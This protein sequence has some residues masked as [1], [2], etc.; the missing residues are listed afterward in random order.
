MAG[1]T[2]EIFDKISILYNGI[3]LTEIDIIKDY[4][5]FLCAKLDSEN[6]HT[7]ALAL[8]TGSEFYNIIALTLSAL[9]CLFYKNTNIE[10][11]IKSLNVDDILI[12]DGQ[13]ARFKGIK[14]GSELG[15]GFNAGEEYFAYELSKAYKWVKLASA[16]NLNISVYQGESE[17][18][19]GKG[20]KSTL[21]ARKDFLRKFTQTKANSEITTEISNSIA[22]I[23]NRDTAERWYRGVGIRYDGRTVSL[24]ELV[25]AAYYSENDKYQ[26]G[27]NAT[28]EEPIIRF[29]SKISA[30][31]E[32]II[33]DKSKS[34]IGC[35]LT[36]ENIWKANSET[37][38]IADRKSLKFAVLTGK[39]HF[40]DY[41]NWFD[42]EGY[43]YYI[44]VPESVSMYPISNSMSAEIQSF[45]KELN[46]FSKRKVIE[47]IIPTTTESDVVFE[48]KRK[49]LVIKHSA[50]TSVFKDN[51]IINSFFLLNL[52]RSSIFPLCYCD[53]AAEQKL[54][55]WNLKDKFDELVPYLKES[56]GL[57][58][59]S[60]EFIVDNLK[61]L[62]NAIYLENPKGNYIKN[63]IANS[64]IDS[65][66]VTKSYY[67]LLFFMWMRDIGIAGV[68]VPK[69]V[70]VSSFA[71]SNAV[72]NN[73]IFTTA[74]YD[75]FFN[76]FAEFG[77]L[78]AECLAYSYECHQIRALKKRAYDGK[79]LIREKNSINYE[80]DIEDDVDDSKEEITIED[81]ECE[82]ELEKLA[83]DLQLSGA[84]SYLKTS[85]KGS[86]SQI[87][88]AKILTFASGNLGFFTKQ[89]KAY[90]ITGEEICEVDL[91][92][93]NVGDSVVFT[94]Q[95]DN[96]DIVDLLVRQ[97]LENQYK[98][99]AYPDYYNKSIQWKEAIKRLK[100]VA[101]FTF[102]DISDM[103]MILGCKK[104]PGTIR[105]WLFEESHIVGPRDE[106]DFEAIVKLTRMDISAHELKK[107]CDEIRSLRVRILGLL[108]K[109]IIRGMV[110]G[111]EDPLW[112]LIEAKAEDLSQIEQITAI[113]TPGEDAFVPMYLI[114]KPC[115]V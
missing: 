83:K 67:D 12:I 6:R 35:I 98:E 71:G 27:S 20:I 70:T 85:G 32:D 51:F 111:S 31:R 3:D 65:I 94:K 54:L 84:Y 41:T 24:S 66:V 104:H 52:C 50:T 29:Y 25:T 57:M 13:R 92:N 60:A 37:P 15:I 81:N 17:S 36:E 7:T 68:K 34:F 62:V 8:H 42:S 49:L 91:E 102:Q 95:S 97:L 43:D 33:N 76:P 96:K 88:I 19:D 45:N 44:T 28:K 5:S 77:F 4:A 1:I 18:L 21:K 114:N 100:L 30:C 78:N 86:D 80:I 113:A 112:S 69:L 61:I 23:A 48:I 38:D 109:A 75:L 73:V 56:N 101:G 82:T 107:S 105:S 47:Q 99:T 46:S 55:T 103:L 9:A 53:K 110:S 59:D 93:L 74:Y 115:V 2:K 89:Y 63:R 10:E 22:I 26:I 72:Y 87:K 64:K 79:K 58:K 16:K 39:T 40:T 106:S 11:L 108:G 14:N 90:R